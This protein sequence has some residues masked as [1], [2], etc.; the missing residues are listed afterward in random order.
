VAI[1]GQ[2]ARNHPAVADLLDQFVCVR[3]VQANGLDM[4]LFQFDYDL[5][6][7]VMFLN[8]DRTIYGRYGTRAGHDL[9]KDISLEGFKKA[10][11]GALELHQSYPANR[12]SLA[13]KTG[14]KP[15]VRVPEDFPMLRKVG[16]TATVD[17]RNPTGGNP[18]ACVHCHQINNNVYRSYRGLGRP[19]PDTALWTYPMPNVLGLELD[20]NERA[21]VKVVA[22]GSPAAKGGFLAGDEILTLAGQPIISLADVQWVLH[23]SKEDPDT[24]TA[25]VKRRGAPHSRTLTLPNGWRKQGDFS[26]RACNGIVSPLPEGSHDLTTAEKNQLGLSATAIAIRVIWATRGFQK[27]DVI[28][29]IDGRRSG[30]TTSDVIALSVQQKKPKE[31]IALTVLRAGKEHSM[32]V[33]AR[34]APIE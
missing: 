21:T 10:L 2:V 34:E 28:V 11:D 1:D 12:A 30:L 6:W 4:A 33:E 3:L 23:Q 31:T 20:V 32:Q 25:V 26:W 17:A 8:A 22:P 14:P 9:N 5:T 18:G 16:Y 13:A 27:G 19:I 7:A 15:R 29:A 24:L